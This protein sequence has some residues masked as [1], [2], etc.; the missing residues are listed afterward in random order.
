[1]SKLT[2]A[3]AAATVSVLALGVTV[4]SADAANIN[5]LCTTNNLVTTNMWIDGGGGATQAIPPGA[6]VRILAYRDSQNYTIRYN[7]NVGGWAR[8]LINQGS[9]H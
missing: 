2:S 8:I 1:M 4:S 6:T 3:V 9:C 5:D 7:G